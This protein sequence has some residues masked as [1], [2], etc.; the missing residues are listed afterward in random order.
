MSGT[1]RCCV[2]QSL[3]HGLIERAAWQL[4]TRRCVMAFSIADWSDTLQP[5]FVLNALLLL[6]VIWTQA[7]NMASALY[8][9]VLC[10]LLTS[11]KADISVTWWLAFLLRPDWVAKYCDVCMSVCLSAAILKQISSVADEPARRVA[12][13]QT[14]CKQRW[15]LLWHRDFSVFKMAVVRHL[16]FFCGVVGPRK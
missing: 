15:K 16:R 4:E 13:R 3:C 1:E 10:R 9:F 7:R 11:V 12:S 14:C 5:I 6:R 2:A 8:S